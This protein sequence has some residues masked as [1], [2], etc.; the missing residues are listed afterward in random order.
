MQGVKVKISL[1]DRLSDQ[2]LEDVVLIS[3]L[4]YRDASSPAMDLLTGGKL[5]L[6]PDLFRSMTLACLIDGECYI[7][8][9]VAT[10]KIVGTALWFPPGKHLWETEEIRESTGLNV[11]LDKLD[12]A[13]KEW[14]INE[15][16]AEV[17]KFLDENYGPETAQESWWLNNIAVLPGYQG[18][19]IGSSLCQRVLDKAASNE[20]VGCCT[21][22]EENV[23]FYKSL[24]FKVIGTLYMRH[25]TDGSE[26][27]IWGL[28]Q[29]GAR[30]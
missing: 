4:A 5:E 14:W 13:A 25:P 28:K 30:G 3:D 8:T 10:Q 18:N 24:R 9:E 23:D 1:V 15:Y 11:F 21:D 7:A 27:K 19:G 17:G 6:I 26:I 12:Q 29:H 16:Q 2:E 20:A 22:T